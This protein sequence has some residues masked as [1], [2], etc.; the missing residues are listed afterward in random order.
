MAQQQKEM[1]WSQSHFWTS[2]L[3]VIRRT[4][5]NLVLILFSPQQCAKHM[6]FWS[7]HSVEPM[8]VRELFSY[9]CAAHWWTANMFM[10]NVANPIAW[11]DECSSDWFNDTS[12]HPHHSQLWW[13]QM[14]TSILVHDFHLT[15]S[16]LVQTSHLHHTRCTICQWMFMG[17]VFCAHRN[18]ITV[19]TSSLVN[20]LST[21]AI[22]QVTL[23]YQY[24]SCT[25][26]NTCHLGDTACT[27]AWQNRS[28]QSLY[29]NDRA[30]LISK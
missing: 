17:S 25:S 11:E 20:L 12:L 24:N 23:C 3:S 7:G 16:T 1:F 8:L 4:S 27:N 10:A 15:T 26:E 19:R 28:L 9:S 29:S 13:W 6:R 14:A 2:A 30:S 22:F 5:L 18:Q 21:V